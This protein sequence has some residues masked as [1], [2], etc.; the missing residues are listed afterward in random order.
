MPNLRRLVLPESDNY[1]HA[2]SLLTSSL[3]AGVGTRSISPAL[4]KGLIQAIAKIT[5]LKVT[6]VIVTH[7]HADHIYGLQEF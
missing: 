6:H 3:D 7:Y 1:S 4:A 2:K 5:P